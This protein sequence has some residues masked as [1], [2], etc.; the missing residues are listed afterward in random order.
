[1][2]EKIEKT[3]EL[4]K[5]NAFMEYNHIEIV[6]IE[7]D[8]AVLKLDIRPESKNPYGMVHGGLL[9]TLADNVTGIAAHT[10]GRGYV[11]QNSSVYFIGNQSEGTIYAHAKV[12]HRG[13]A[14]CVVSF[15]ITGD[16]DR[17]LATGEFTMFC[18]HE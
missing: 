5:K 2:N 15:E 9:S 11:S 17:L 4:E 16:G 8:E 7:P 18:I 3:R 1:M 13:R 6:S 10:D 12:R 14:T